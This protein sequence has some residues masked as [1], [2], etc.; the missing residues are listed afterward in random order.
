MFGVGVRRPENAT[1][2]GGPNYKCHIKPFKVAH[3]KPSSLNG[4][5]AK[6][7][8]LLS[9]YEMHFLPQKAVKNK[10]WRIFWLS[11]QIREWPNFM[12]ISQTSLLK[13]VWLRLLWRTGVATLLRRCI[14]NGSAREYR[15]RSRGSPCLPIELRNPS[16]ILINWSMFQQCSGIQCSLN[17]DAN[18]QW[19][20]H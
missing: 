8:I 4:R 16:S 18:R 7:D 19:D 13:F 2:L 6:W 9:Q 12:R 1:L 14:K 5:L 15:S 3:D 20:W 17:R 11:I 10:Q